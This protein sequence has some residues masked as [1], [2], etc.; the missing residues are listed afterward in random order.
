MA[1]ITKPHLCTVGMVWSDLLLIDVQRSM[2][3]QIVYRGS[4]RFPS[5]K[6]LEDSEGANHSH[7]RKVE[8]APQTCEMSLPLI[9]Q[10][11]PNI[12]LKPLYLASG[13]PPPDRLSSSSCNKP[14]VQLPFATM[15]GIECV[16]HYSLSLSVTACRRRRSG[17]QKEEYQSF[18]CTD[19]ILELCKLNSADP[20]QIAVPSAKANL[21]PIC[22]R[23]QS[24]QNHHK[25][26]P[27]IAG[28]T[29]GQPPGSAFGEAFAL[30]RAMRR[31]C[32]ISTGQTIVGCAASEAS[33]EDLYGARPAS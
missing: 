16:R 21:R 13:P 18:R 12:A 14:G 27:L 11:I 28:D 31:Y 1:P 6:L 25:R 8:L 7:S 10:S 17:L 20:I 26:T 22:T 33:R 24:T 32:A 3:V 29:Q 19:P 23:T 9:H 4:R 30:S 15:H 2:A 5:C